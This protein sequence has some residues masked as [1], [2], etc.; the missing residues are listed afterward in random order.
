[1]VF[2]L[3]KTKV[4]LV[5]SR[6]PLKGKNV[7]QNPAHYCLDPEKSKQERT[8]AKG[9]SQLIAIILLVVGI[10]LLVWGSNLYGA[11]GNTFTRAIDGSTDTKTI[12]VLA[13]GAVCT[14][15]GLVKLGGR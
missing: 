7:C 3:Q 12:V 5:L 9:N 4:R 8:M 13:S 6:G 15:L 14:L 2:F 1:V 10:A 11:F